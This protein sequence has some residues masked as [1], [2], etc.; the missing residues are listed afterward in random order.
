M[1]KKMIRARG[2][3]KRDIPV[4]TEQGVALLDRVRGEYPDD[5]DGGLIRRGLAAL[6]EAA[7][8]PEGM[9]DEPGQSTGAAMT[10]E[11]GREAL[12]SAARK[13]DEK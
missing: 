7:R 8:E 12:A 13:L 1:A 3:A 6:K 5:S 9:H 4:T 10:V 11:V 2:G